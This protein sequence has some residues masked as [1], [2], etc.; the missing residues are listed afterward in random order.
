MP[1]INYEVEVKLRGFIQLTVP[2]N[3]AP[4]EFESWL[5]ENSDIPETVDELLGGKFEHETE[6]ELSVIRTGEASE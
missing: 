4:E 3:V 5:E 2:S 6:M 1:K